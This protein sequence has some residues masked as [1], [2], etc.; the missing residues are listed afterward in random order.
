[1]LKTW[2]LK[3][4]K[5]GKNC[6]LN[7][8]LKLIWYN[9]YEIYVQKTAKRNEKKYFEAKLSQNASLWSVLF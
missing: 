8:N 3:Q 1:M 5:K 4:A 2:A 9:S 6:K 7:E